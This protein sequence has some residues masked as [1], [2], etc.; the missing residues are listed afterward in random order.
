MLVTLDGIVTLSSTKEDSKA[1]APM[2]VTVKPLM[3]V[4]MVTAPPDPV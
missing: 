2:P 4:G 3:L 1:L